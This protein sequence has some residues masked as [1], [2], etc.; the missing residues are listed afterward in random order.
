MA[1]ILF[2]SAC[3][4]PKYVRYSSEFGDFVAQVPWGWSV[5]LD[6]SGSVHYGYTFVGPFEPD[7][8]RG[9][10][11]LN[12]RWYAYNKYHRLPHG[13]SDIFFSHEDYIRET[14]REVYGPDRYLEQPVHRVA[15]SGWEGSH[16]VVVSPVE[17]PPDTRFGVSL[18]R[19]GDKVVVLRQHAYVVLPMDSGFYV[20]IYPATR[21]GYGK[22]LDRFNHLVNTFRVIKDGPAGEPV[23]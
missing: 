10:P 6:E 19:D 21:G 4:P 16:F 18:E 9:V 15:V 11:T 23:R 3:N 20:M 17:V 1:G 7:F 14:L 12:I 5:Y 2:V 22:Y 13:R 8:F